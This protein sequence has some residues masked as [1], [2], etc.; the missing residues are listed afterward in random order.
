MK[1]IKRIATMLLTICLIVPCFSMVALAADGVIYF[2]DLETKVGDTFTITGT[3][4]ARG[5]VVGD[6]TVNMS[7]DTNFIKFVEGDGVNADSNGGLTF[8][9]SGDGNSDT[10]EFSMTFQALQEG[11]TRMEQGSATV[12]TYY[13]ETVNC[14]YGYSDIVIGAGDPSKIQNTDTT[15][16]GD[17]SVTIDEEQYTISD[18]FSEMELYTGFTV[19]EITYGGATYKGAVQ[20]ASGLAMVYL[21]N[22][23]QEGAFW[24]YNAE[25][26]SFSPAEEVVISDEYS[27]IIYDGRSE[28]RMPEKY[29][30]GTLE[31]NGKT[32]PI[33]NEPD[34]EGFY[35]LYAVNNEGQKSLY[36]YDSTEHT[37]QRMETPKTATTAKKAEGMWDKFSEMVS[38]YLIWFV[39]GIGC[40]AFLLIIFLIVMAV[41]LHH[42][43]AELDDLYDEYGID[44]DD[45]LEKVNKKDK[46]R[47]QFKKAP[48][49]DFDDF[50]EDDYD[51]DYEDEYDDEYEDD[52]DKSYDEY[53]DDD[54]YEDD[55]A[56][57]R[58]EFTAGRAHENL[59][60]FYEDEDFDE[61]IDF[62]KVKKRKQRKD[63]TFEMD[64]IDLD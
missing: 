60:E 12:S 43:N 54:E 51:D 27:I 28:V 17:G 7:Y 57:L 21:V 1:I 11:S 58:R 29:E 14:E 44:M 18:A 19:G 22:S 33:W 63:E 23:A 52:Y 48:E 41:K 20:E 15:A 8:T 3:V 24:M 37:Y 50:Y 55:L 49:D 39:V 40:V 59:D 34:R 25:E 6:T 2:T 47:N 13:G 64:F 5:D 38:N 30:E 32:L 26:E 16:T 61:T 10:L 31:I 4:V 53:Y 46:K 9:G 56:D 35:I 36:T 62:G 42:R 45:K